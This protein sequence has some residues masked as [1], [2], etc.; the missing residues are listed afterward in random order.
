M[1]L[2]RSQYEVTV[3]HEAKL[4]NLLDTLSV[5]VSNAVLVLPA[6]H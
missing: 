4:N 2:W 5:A 6:A 1:C 3:V